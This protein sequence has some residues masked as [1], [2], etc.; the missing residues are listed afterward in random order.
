MIGFISR[1]NNETVE[2]TVPPALEIVL[3]PMF[4][5]KFIPLL[6]RVIRLLQLQGNN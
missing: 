4:A 1:C 2:F 5:D 6:K 3:T